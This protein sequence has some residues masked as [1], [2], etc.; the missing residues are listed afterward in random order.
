MAQANPK[1]SPGRAGND[2]SA[3]SASSF[4]LLRKCGDAMIVAAAGDYGADSLKNTE[5]PMRHNSLF[6]WIDRNLQQAS[7]GFLP[8]RV[9]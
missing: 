6:S 5:A 4:H 3:D 8:A 9:G 7:L 2:C 1:S